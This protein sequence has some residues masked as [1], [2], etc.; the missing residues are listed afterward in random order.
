M[1]KKILIVDDEKRLVSLV[2]EYLQQAGYRV[3]SAYD[4]KEALSI[5]R[6][7]KPDL[8]ILDLMMPEMNGYEFIQA[9]RKEMDTPI[10]LLTARV[11]DEEKV[12]GLELGADDYVTKP[13]RPRELVARVRSVL[14]RSGKSESET[15]V[16]HVSDVRL[17][18]NIRTVR[19]GETYI[20][21]T[22]S[23]FDLLAAL[24][25]N[26]GKVFTRLDLL[27]ILQGIRYEGYERTID[28]HIKNLRAKME[29]DSR[30]PRYIE[31][32]Y[33]IGYRFTRE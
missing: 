4:G 11:E 10:I 20:N 17:D 23:E 29:P 22:P 2:S 7:E 16:L 21:L 18:R 26:P 3:V 33:G 27:D 14:R 28:S 9:H 15:S 6:L 30:S 24:M 32:V 31:T 8:I 12:I 5:A 25:A 1:Q 13:F 19:V